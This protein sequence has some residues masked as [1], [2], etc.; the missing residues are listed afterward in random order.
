VVVSQGALDNADQDK[1]LAHTLTAP[2]TNHTLS[3]RPPAEWAP[4]DCGSVSQQGMS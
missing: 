4:D 1:L 2:K 3:S